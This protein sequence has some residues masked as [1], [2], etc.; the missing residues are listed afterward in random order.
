MSLLS[1]KLK[2]QFIPTISTP[3]PPRHIRKS[4]TRHAMFL[5]KSS[6]LRPGLLRSSLGMNVRTT[7]TTSRVPLP[8]LGRGYDAL[9]VDAVATVGDGGI[10]ASTDVT[11]AAAAGGVCGSAGTGGF[12]CVETAVNVFCVVEACKRQHRLQTEERVVQ[13]G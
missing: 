11:C 12:G 8:F 3:P 5:R 4:Q 7:T 13:G 2:L 9:F 6:T 10:G 1:K